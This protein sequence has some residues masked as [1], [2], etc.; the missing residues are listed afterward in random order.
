MIV[1]AECGHENTFDQ[2]YPYHAGF[3]NQGFLYNDAGNRTLVWGSYDPAWERLVGRIHPWMLDE[4]GWARVE[5]ALAPAADGTRWKASNQPRCR[6]CGVPIG[7]SIGEG[8]IHYL[9]YPGSLL[10]DEP[11][12]PNQFH[13]AL[14]HG[15]SAA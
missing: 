3:G 5:A 14:E 4:A 10:L 6:T 1:R 7:H 12:G 2:P 11:E 13:R 15:H 8:E 9:V